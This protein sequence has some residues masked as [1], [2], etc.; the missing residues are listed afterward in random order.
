MPSLRAGM[1]VL[2]VGAGLLGAAHGADAATTTT[3]DWVC[4]VAYQPARQVW[5][6]AVRLTHDARRLLEVAIDGVPVYQFA[7][8]DT[9]ILTSLDNERVQID[10]ASRTWSSDFRGLAQG[11]GRCEVGG[12]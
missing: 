6:R 3:T 10:V 2:C 8:L 11:R 12:P 1:C 5:P 4:E 7:V 9:L